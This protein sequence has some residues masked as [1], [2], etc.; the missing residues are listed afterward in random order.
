MYYDR[1]GLT[2]CT[3]LP[4]EYATRN[5]NSCALLV[6]QKAVNF[7]LLAPMISM[8]TFTNIYQRIRFISSDIP[9]QLLLATL[10][11]SFL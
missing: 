3:H 7:S 8:L 9:Q 10:P 5:T 1:F 11:T 6:G 4:E 2:A